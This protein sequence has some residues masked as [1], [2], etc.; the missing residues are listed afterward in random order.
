MSA[1]AE[2]KWAPGGEK[3]LTTA[4]AYGLLNALYYAEERAKSNAVVRGGNRSFLTG[5]HLGGPLNIKD[6]P[7]TKRAKPTVG[8]TLRRSIFVSV[9]LNGSPIPGSRSKDENGQ[10]I[11]GLAPAGEVT[12][13]IGTNCGYGGWVDGGTSKMPARPMIVPA[14]QEMSA[15]L[16]SLF[17]AGFNKAAAR[18][19]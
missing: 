17:I 4:S 19:G 9:F 8:G 12:G 5:S 13:F 11:E 10:S 16:Q 15:S 14:I 6:L 3:A 7:G 1:G 2:F 18:L